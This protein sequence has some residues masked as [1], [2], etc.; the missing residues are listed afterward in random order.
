MIEIPFPATAPTKLYAV[1]L[2]L[3]PIQYGTLMPFSGELVHAAIWIALCRKTRQ[4]VAYAIGD[5]SKQTCQR[6]WEAIPLAYRQGHCF[7]N[8]WAAY[9]AVIP[10]EQHTAVGKETGETAHVERW[11]NTALAASGPF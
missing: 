5:R 9:K 7:T 10:E 11:N 6:L 1:L 8:F 4:V 2:K 3:R